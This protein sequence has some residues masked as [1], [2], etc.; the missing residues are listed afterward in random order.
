[1][2]SLA[3]NQDR[4]PVSLAPFYG[5]VLWPGVGGTGQV[6]LGLLLTHWAGFLASRSDSEGGQQGRLG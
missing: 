1:M 4:P 2:L 5:A 6:L 3:C